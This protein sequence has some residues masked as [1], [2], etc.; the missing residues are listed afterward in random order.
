MKRILLASVG[1][2]AM[3]TMAS[4]A[5]LPRS[6][7]YKAPAAYAPGFNWTGFYAGLHLGYGWGSA[8]SMDM[9]G[10]FVGGQVGYNWQAPGSP[11]VFGVELDSSWADFGD[12]GAFVGNAGTVVLGSTEANYQGSL[13]GR[14]G[15]SFGRTMLYA[16]GGLGWLH[17][18]VRVAA[19]AGAFPVG[20]VDSKTH[21]GGVVG[22]GVEHAIAPNWTGKLEYLYSG[23]GNET[24]FAPQ[25]G[26]RIDA[27]THTLKVGINYLFR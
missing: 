15:Y 20:A 24:Y 25:G 11:W 26:A 2:V 17:N 8:A 10:A 9:D 21:L 12:N 1:V 6:M 4:A 13:R 22:A 3:V 7:P 19:T 14:V 27:D 5:D 16:T 23:Y 18:E